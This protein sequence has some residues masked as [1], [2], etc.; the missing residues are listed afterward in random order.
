MTRLSI[1]MVFSTLLICS[2][3]GIVSAGETNRLLSH[4]PFDKPSVLAVTKRDTATSQPE[5]EME[6]LEITATLVSDAM[7]MV[8]AAGE[9]LGIGE[10]VSGYR[11]ISVAEGK[12]TFN[13]NGKTYTF[14]LLDSGVEI[15]P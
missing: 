14:S 6:T 12:A 5:E 10:S 11:L 3:T 8:I 9:M 15:E 1:A 2:W 4:N 13:K 7:P